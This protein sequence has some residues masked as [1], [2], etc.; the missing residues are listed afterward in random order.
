M[1][2]HPVTFPGRRFAIIAIVHI[3]TIVVVAG[4]LALALTPLLAK[5]QSGTAFIRVNQLGYATTA[6]KRAYLM[7][8]AA[9]TGATFS[10]KNASGANVFSAPIGANLGTW[11]TSYDTD[12]HDG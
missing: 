12:S 4:A 11:S 5:A 9:E 10:V 3:A 1:N 8:S 7:A 6:S 2:V